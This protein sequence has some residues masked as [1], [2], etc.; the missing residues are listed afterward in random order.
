MKY[1]VFGVLTFVYVNVVMCQPQ[2]EGFVSLFNGESLDGWVASEENS[3]SFFVED[4]KLVAKGGRAHLFYNGEVGDHDF[5]NFEMRLK[6]MTTAASN[7]GVYFHTRYQKSGW[8]DTGFEAQVNSKH[9]DMR[10]TGSLYGVV[11]IWV[12]G[13]TEEP[14]AAR[15]DKA[16][17]VYIQRDEAPSK[18]GEWFD[19]YIKVEGDRIIV[20]VDG[21]TTVD[22]TQPIGWSKDRRIGHGTIGFQAHDPSC[23][24]YY[25]DIE[26]KVLPESD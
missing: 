5:S 3:E 6:V 11:N 14:Y 17:Q 22:W 19:Y 20:R 16:G 15:V 9:A 21:Q 12:P 7:S 13:D 26:I 24:V 8:P 4:G 1:L 25:K 2:T 23:L 18:D 10:K